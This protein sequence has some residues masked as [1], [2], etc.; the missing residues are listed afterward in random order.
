MEF[1]LLGPLEFAVDGRTVELPA[2][3]PRVL[4][5]LLLVEARRVVATERLID[6][7]WDGRPPASGPKIG[8]VARRRLP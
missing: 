4:L 1:R 5:A 7:L 2:G 8:A 3:R 6:Q